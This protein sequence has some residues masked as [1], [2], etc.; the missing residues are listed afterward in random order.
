MIS[1]AMAIIAGWILPIIGGI[2]LIRLAMEE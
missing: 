1:L 2:Q